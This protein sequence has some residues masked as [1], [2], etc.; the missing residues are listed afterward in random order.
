MAFNQK[1]WY[2][3]DESGNVPEGA[4]TI[5]ANNLNRIEAGIANND[6]VC[7][8]NSQNIEY[9]RKSIPIS[10]YLAFVGQ[11][12]TDMVSAAFGK[13]NEDD[14][15]GV[16]K[17]LSMYAKF[18]GETASTEF[19]E[20]YDSYNDLVLSHKYDLA[21]IP[22]I[23]ELIRSNNY[24]HDILMNTV[25]GLPDIVIYDSGSANYL[26]I[27]NIT[28]SISFR[29]SYA[30]KE[31][32]DY[33]YSVIPMDKCIQFNLGT[34]LEDEATVQ[35]NIPIMNMLPSI[36]GYRYLNIKLSNNVD[37]II[38]PE[39]KNTKAAYIAVEFNG[40]THELYSASSQ[41]VLTG[42]SINKDVFDSNFTNSSLASMKIILKGKLYSTQNSIIDIAKIAIEKIWL[43]ET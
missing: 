28:K 8:A 37:S 7:E 38:F 14:L 34:R 33:T 2:V 25:A 26:D 3:K 42:S 16:G 15:L 1:T 27:N 24:A 10:P 31:G 35:F 43:S 6:R 19:M 29:S 36:K 30:W 11:V 9:L 12:N 4:P 18:K 21:N 22:S 17:A 23:C 40:I 41:T 32:K 39:N 5:N 20:E 13:G